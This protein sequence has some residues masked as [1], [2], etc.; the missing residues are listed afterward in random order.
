MTWTLR[1]YKNS[2]D[3]SSVPNTALFPI[4]ANELT[5]ANN[6]SRP[7]LT[8]NVIRTYEVTSGPNAGNLYRSDGTYLLAVPAG[9][10]L[11]GPQGPAGPQG[12]QGVQGPAGVQGIQGPQGIQGATGAVGDRGETGPAGPEGVAGPQ[13]EQGPRGLQ[14]VQGP[15]GP[16]G[17]Q[18]PKGDP[19]PQGVQGFTGLQGNT[20]A[21][22]PQGDT[23]PQGVQGIKGDRGD[24]GAAGSPG[25]TG[26]GLLPVSRTNP[27][28]VIGT[29]YLPSTVNP[30]DVA[31]MVEITQSLT[32]LGTLVDE[33]GLFV[34]GSG[35]GTSGGTEVE[36][37][38]S[39]ITG[40]AITVGMG[41]K[42]RVP[43]RARLAPGEY[44]ALRQLQGSGTRVTVVKASYTVLA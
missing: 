32:V 44:F 22:G 30:V 4:S 34:G 5:A 3:Y 11:G 36:S 13:G 33:V 28:V 19:G 10:D 2:A 18:G 40:I 38:L 7:D 41:Q 14:G 25:A 24:Q 12:A 42:Q 1:N 35:V 20:G 31:V 15:Q 21:T 27:T 37:T 16:E 6:G 26:P 17:I 29:A 23:G 8:G 9:T 39:S 43:L